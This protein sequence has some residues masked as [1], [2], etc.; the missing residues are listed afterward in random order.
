MAMYF[1]T[2]LRTML[3]GRAPV[4]QGASLSVSSR[5]AAVTGSPDSFTDSGSGFVTAG[6]AVGDTV[7]VSGFAT[8]ANN[9]IFTITSV[10]AGTIEISETT[11]V[12]ESAGALNIKVQCIAGGSLKDIFKDGILRLYSGTAPATADATATGSVLL[13]VTVASG[14]WVAGT[15][16]NGL[17]FGTAASGVIAKSS[18]VWSGVGLVTD[19]AGYFRLYANATDATTTSTTLP[20]IQGTV[21]TSGADLNM[22]SRR[23]TLGATTTIDTFQL[24]FPATA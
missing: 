4:L 23:I 6:F 8:A 13:E 7:M 2:G 12:N 1:S 22:S 17:E 19:D 18:A 20:R 14:A 21:G 9:G 16:T 24:T 15:P 5:I 10:A 3:W 11:V